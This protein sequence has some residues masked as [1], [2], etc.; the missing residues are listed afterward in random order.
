MMKVKSTYKAINCNLYDQLLLWSSRKVVCDIFFT[1]PTV[2][3]I[4]NLK[5]IITDVFTK[6]KIEYL[7]L[8]DK[9]II[10]LDHIKEINN[11]SFDSTCEL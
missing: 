2:E 8:D 6:E 3:I 7:K 5:G 9:Q 4:H 1:D 10:R 11:I